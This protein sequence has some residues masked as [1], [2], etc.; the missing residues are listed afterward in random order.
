MDRVTID[1][2]AIDPT[3][4]ARAAAVLAAGGL[5]AYPTDTF[6]G[7]AADPRNVE[8]VR[9]LFDAKGR[10]PD[11]ASP[12]I[13][14][15][16]AQAEQ[17]VEFTDAARILATHFWPG[18]LSLVLPARPSV[19]RAVLGGG[20]TAAVR[21]PDHSIARALAGAAG[22]CITA[23]SANRSGGP[24]AQ[25]PNAIDAV[26][27]AH[28]DLLIDGGQTPG[29]AASTIVDLTDRVP[30]LVRHGAIAWDRVLESL[31]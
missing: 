11:Q 21:V 28:I 29:L 13:A 9:K 24:P 8:A 18:P 7:L 20:E 27:L 6:Y 16:S 10:S 1:P 2:S 3:A 25:L 26:L 17:A 12:L 15:T 22:F 31:K 14:A 30:R 19:Q 4:I 5:V 23:T